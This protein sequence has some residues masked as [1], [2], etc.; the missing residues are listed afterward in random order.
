MPEVRWLPRAVR[1]LERLSAFLYEKNPNAARKA[2]SLIKESAITLESFPEIDTP[3]S[4]DPAFRELFASFGQS[5]YIV[6]YR[7][8]R[9]GNVVISRVW[10]SR[11]SR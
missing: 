2:I 3:W 4:K 1:D 11:E 7:M 8:D 9:N 5:A 6:R 10:H